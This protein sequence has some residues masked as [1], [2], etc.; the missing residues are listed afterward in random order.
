VQDA[1]SRTKSRRELQG[2]D[3]FDDVSPEVGELNSV[4][5]DEAMAHDPD[6]ALSMLADM[7]GATDEKLRALA[8]RLAGSIMVDLARRG[9][10]RRRG[11]G[12][13]VSQPFQPDGGDLDLDASMHGIVTA[14]ATASAVD[15]DDLRINGWVKPA[16]AYCLLV[17]RSGSMHGT[18]LANSA[19]AAAAVSH[20]AA[21]YSVIAFAGDAVVTKSQDSDKSIE[22]VVNDVLVLRGAGTTDVALALRSA[23]VQLAR[24]RAGRKITVLLS[25]CR[26]TARGDMQAAASGLDELVILAPEGDADDAFTF[27]RAV[28]ARV[29]TVAG[30]SHLPAALA[31][32]L[33][34]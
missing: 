9:R 30:P 3:H 14:R 18:P 13:L 17:D 25:D 10:T 31:E 20:R 24:S 21:D 5:F 1:A 7:T 12:K 27:G 16:T 29:V 33:G 26:A 34:D 19:I 28:G 8:R 32:A 22:A 6:A 15:I 11:I 23:H 4:S 2:H